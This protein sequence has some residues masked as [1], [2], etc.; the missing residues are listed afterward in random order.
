MAPIFRRHGARFAY[1]FGSRA[2]GRGRRDSDYDFAVSL[3]PVRG[4]D[5]V[6]D[7]LWLDL[8]RVLRTDRIDLVLLEGSDLIV[9]D[10]VE[11]TGRLIYEHD[12]DARIR[13]E[14]RTRKEAWD[15]TPHWAVHDAALVRRLRE[16]TFGR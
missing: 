4:E 13:F 10:V 7:A 5:D 15:E 6:T 11:R 14:C 9:R 1:L 2:C 3:T 8:V 12:R 16:G